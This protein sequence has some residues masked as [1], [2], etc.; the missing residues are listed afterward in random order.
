MMAHLL[1]RPA[2]FASLILLA[3]YSIS[4]YN[5]WRQGRKELADLL[6]GS[7][8]GPP[9]PEIL[10]DIRAEPDPLRAE[11]RAARALLAEE[12]ERGRSRRSPLEE[13][14]AVLLQGI[15]NLRRARELASRALRKRPAAW[16]AAMVLGGATYL[17]RGRSRDPGTTLDREGWVAPLELA[18]Q[19]GP[20]Q[21]EP[22]RFLI[23]AHLSDWSRLSPGLR[24]EA[25]E[26]IR[27]AFEDPVS[28]TL[29]LEQW[30]RVAP[31][32]DQAM[33]AIPDAPS[34]W[35]RVRELYAASK[36][37][38]RYCHAQLQWNRALHKD[39]QKRLTRA[40]AVSTGGDS[41]RS[42]GLLL[43]LISDAPVRADFQPILAQAL[44]LL[45]P[46]PVR[47]HQIE[48]LREWIEW[49]R[50]RC[51]SGS[52]P[53]SES[54][55]ER[56]VGLAELREHALIAEGAIMA[57]DLVK[58][59]LHER[60]GLIPYSDTW[61]PYLILKADLL[62]RRDDLV[63]ARADLEL[64]SPGWQ[65]RPAFQRVRSAV[66]AR[67]DLQSA[68]TRDPRAAVWVARE[69]SHRRR[70]ARLELVPATA[71]VDLEIEFADVHSD[72]AVVEVRW[73]G[74]LLG[75]FPLRPQSRLRLDTLAS[76]TPQLLEIL[77]LSGRYARPG[78]VR[79]RSAT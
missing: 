47:P 57:G 45:P 12:L 13:D 25:A 18:R 9:N 69:W 17:E 58:A 15:E 5:L 72:G 16:Q 55:I 70:Y 37:W 10:A 39:L 59:E 1:F 77:V 38:E 65:Q 3:V 7:G 40:R 8:P 67:A 21:P 24:Q 6:A 22:L 46:G 78:T 32:F 50:D 56:M 4:D 30:L 62:T 36:D 48:K 64:V 73:N 49:T 29:F 23:A 63:E 14:R 41:F 34:A 76:G 33:E 51:L 68:V 20:G 35:S 26:L 31:S 60:R 2:L 19:L 79:L 28:L 74:T 42:R 43:S 52:C 11:L 54:T 66:L 27:E 44:D 75:F 61:S 53:L 71:R